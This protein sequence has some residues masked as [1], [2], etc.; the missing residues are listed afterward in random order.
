MKTL[1]IFFFL[2]FI[3]SILS[4]CR[5]EQAK[6]ELFSQ[7]AFA[8]S[9]DNGW[10]LN[11]S[12]VVKGFFQTENDTAYESKIS[13]SVDLITPADTLRN[14]DYGIINRKSAEELL[15]LSIESQVEIDSSFSTGSYKVVFNVVDELSKRTVKAEKMFELSED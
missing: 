15:D 11:A 5:K 13:Y 8:F 6:L 2:C 10:E 12:A 1:I 4:A 7:E 3:L 9:V 14:V